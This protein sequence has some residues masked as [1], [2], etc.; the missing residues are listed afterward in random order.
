MMKQFFVLILMIAGL[1]NCLAQEV[2]GDIAQMRIGPNLMLKY[3]THKWVY[4]SAYEDPKDTLEFGRTKAEFKDQDISGVKLTLMNISSQSPEMAMFATT[5][6]LTSKKLIANLHKTI[7]GL[8]ALMIKVSDPKKYHGFSYIILKTGGDAGPAEQKQVVLI[9]CMVSQGEIVSL[10]TLESP[11][12]FSDVDKMEKEF[13]NAVNSISVKKVSAE[14]IKQFREKKIPKNFEEP[15]VHNDVVTP[16]EPMPD[17]YEKFTEKANAGEYKSSEYLNAIINSVYPDSIF[18]KIMKAD[19][20]SGTYSTMFMTGF[21]KKILKEKYNDT[22]EFSYAPEKFE[23]IETEGESTVYQAVIHLATDHYMLLW[24]TKTDTAWKYNSYVTETL[25]TYQDFNASVMGS[26]AGLS[27][28]FKAS[29]RAFISPVISNN[30]PGK[31]IN[32]SS[33][34]DSQFVSVFRDCVTSS[35]VEDSI[36]RCT[37]VVHNINAH[38]FTVFDSIQDVK[39]RLQFKDFTDLKN[40]LNSTDYYGLTAKQDSIDVVRTSAW[41]G[42]NDSITAEMR[43]YYTPLFSADLDDDGKLDLYWAAFSNGKLIY[44]EAF[45]QAG[46]EWNKLNQSDIISNKIIKYKDCLPY[47]TH[48]TL[49]IAPPSGE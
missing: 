42:L 13:K 7:S 15:P 43:M 16:S 4:S 22:L 2:S 38:H 41:A 21:V 1:A 8:S 44:Y 31:L 23:E 30:S 28:L 46:K 5:G 20:S 47:I 3:N 49:K 24:A 37:T 9:S 45:K 34:I 35:D 36:E 11:K 12:E 40:Y 19:L 25:A 48:S 27:I 32:M 18:Y 33:P 26:G 14:V 29:E 39:A 10:M 17:N 6:K